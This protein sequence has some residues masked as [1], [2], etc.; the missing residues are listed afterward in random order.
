MM[1][2]KTIGL[3]N[4]QVVQNF[5]MTHNLP[6]SSKNQIKFYIVN[7]D[8]SKATGEFCIDNDECQSGLCHTTGLCQIARYFARAQRY[9]SN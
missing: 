1:V 9:A 2:L 5:E 4:C 6:R 8:R 3:T 7:L